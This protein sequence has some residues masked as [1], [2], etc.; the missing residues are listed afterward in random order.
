MGFFSKFM[1]GAKDLTVLS[2]SVSLVVDHL[3]MYEIEPNDGL[4]LIAAWIYKAGIFDMI[5]KNGW[6]PHYK[7]TVY[8]RKRFLSMSLM[9]IQS[10]TLDPILSKASEAYDAEL[11]ADIDDIIAGGPAFNEVGSLVPQQIKDQMFNS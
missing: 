5:T 8:L 9:E 1:S 11:E 10:Y 3:D 6:P 4:L 2:K 7:T